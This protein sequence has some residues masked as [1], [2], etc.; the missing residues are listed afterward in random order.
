MPHDTPQDSTGK[1][2]QTTDTDTD[3]SFRVGIST[4][5]YVEESWHFPME[6]GLARDV[7]SSQATWI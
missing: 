7:A 3:V 2:K 5:A 4:A 1:A 6:F